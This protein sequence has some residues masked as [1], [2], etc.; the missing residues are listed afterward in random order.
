MTQVFE[1]STPC[2]ADRD[3]DYER[4]AQAIAFMRQNVLKQPDLATVA[5]QVHLSE[6][7]FQRLFTRWAG[8]SPKRFLQFLTIEYAKSQITQTRSLFDLSLDIGLSSSG[9]LHDLFVTIEAVSP[10][11]FKLAGAGLQLRYGIHST[12]FGQALIATTE[13]G[14]CHLQFLDPHSPSPQDLLRA[15]WRNAEL[16]FDSS[17]TQSTIDRI[18]QP[19]AFRTDTP[20]VLLVKGTNFQVQVW[21]AL[22]KIPFGGITTY[23]QLATAIQQPTATRAIGNAVGSNAI[24]YLIPCHRVIRGSGEL[25]GYRWGLDRKSAMLGWEA[26]WRQSLQDLP[27]PT[28]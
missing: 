24:A 7:H 23:Q 26:G 5:Q 9:R 21:R 18:F 6:Y 3:S 27:H 2:D 16:E 12:P 13:R 20:F 25:G 17:V 11:E 10:G 1:P 15:E 22:L 14:I 28:A 4:I 8:I 19:S